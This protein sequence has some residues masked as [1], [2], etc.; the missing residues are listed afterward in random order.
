MQNKNIATLLAAGKIPKKVLLNEWKAFM[1]R[2]NRNT[3]STLV[4][5]MYLNTL[6]VAS[7]AANNDI[8][9]T[10]VM[11]QSNNL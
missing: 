5:R 2:H 3:R 8:N 9:P 4:I 6:S 7:R 10:I 1:D 11:K